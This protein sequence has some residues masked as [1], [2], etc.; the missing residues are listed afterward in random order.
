MVRTG[1]FGC[2]SVTAKL[3]HM[4]TTNHATLYNARSNRDNQ[5][6]LFRFDRIKLS[7]VILILVWLGGCATPQTHALLKLNPNHLPQ[8]VELA[9]VPYYPQESHQ[10]G[11]AALATV[12]NAGGTRVTPQDLTPEVYLPG[13]EGSLQVEMLAATR[14]NGLLAY[15]LSPRLDDLL[16]EVAAGS[17]VVVLQNLGLSWYPVWHYAVVVGYD[18]EHEEIIL[19][20]GSERRQVMYLSTFEHTWKRS[21]YWAM[22]ALPP[23]KVPQTVDEGKYVAAAIALEKSGKPGVAEVAYDAS[24]KRWPLNLAARIGLGNAAYA[25]GEMQ[26]AEIAYRQATLDHSDSDIAFNNLAQALADQQ[27]Y[28]EALNA[29]HQAVN[30]GGVV[31]AA[32]RETLQQ[33]SLAAGKLRVTT[34]TNTAATLSTLK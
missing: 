6:R 26:R 3:L 22:L 13:R 4:L 18:L 5:N 30:L 1:K 34:N 25:Q 27:R 24:L 11:P 10:C 20:S 14:R 2:L 8:Q 31:Q 33:I 28:A 32:A 23:D 7:G 19:R 17:P 21:G 12:L 16:R 9:E 15:E 29:A